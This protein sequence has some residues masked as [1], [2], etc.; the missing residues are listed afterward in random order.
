M[1]QQKL[2][3]AG[4]FSQGGESRQWESNNKWSNQMVWLYLLL[5]EMMGACKNYEYFFLV[6][7][8]YN[9]RTV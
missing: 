3:Q 1:E 4:R 7:V 6:L 9:F 2:Y 8:L 5:N